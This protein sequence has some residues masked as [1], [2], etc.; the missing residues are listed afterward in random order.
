MPRP[1]YPTIAWPT[2]G[3]KSAP[4]I[5]TGNQVVG[6]FLPATIAS[7][8][9]KFNAG[10]T[11]DISSS[12][13]WYPVNDSSGA[14]ISFTV[15]ASTAGYYGFSADQIAKFSGLGL[16][17]MVAGSSEAAN[18]LIQLAILPRQAI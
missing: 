6:F 9:I 16:L 15:N 12:I 10:T 4:W 7:T 18:Q 8:S 17:Q 3:T 1:A 13:I 14:Q 11:L 5:A 2:A